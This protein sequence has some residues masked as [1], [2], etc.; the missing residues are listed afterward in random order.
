MIQLLGQNP[1]LGTAPSP[2][3]GFSLRREEI[4]QAQ[5]ITQLEEEGTESTPLILRTLFLRLGSGSVSKV[6]VAPGWD[7][8][9][10]CQKPN[11]GPHTCNPS[12]RKAEAGGSL[13]LA[14]EPV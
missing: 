11:T 12:T 8:Q 5:T 1:P 9:F 13:E 10:P 2:H 6:L 7:S 14:G 3:E 4:L